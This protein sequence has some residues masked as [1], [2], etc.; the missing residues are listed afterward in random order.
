MGA[1]STIFSAYLKRNHLEGRPLSQVVSQDAVIYE[2]VRPKI[3][4]LHSKETLPSA[5]VYD[6]V[7]DASLALRTLPVG[8]SDIFGNA[9]QYSGAPLIGLTSLLY[10]VIGWA[11]ARDSY[12][13]SEQLSEIGDDFNASLARAQVVANGSIAISSGFLAIARILG[14]IEEFCHFSTHSIALP[15]AVTTVKLAATI[16]SSFFYLV[17]NLIYIAGQAVALKKLSDGNALREQL[18]G[19]KDPVK[20]L[21]NHIDAEMFRLGG[22]T[23]EECIEMAL[24]EGERWLEKLEK[25][26]EEPSWEQS[27]ESRKEHAYLLMYNNPQYMMAEMGVTEAFAKADP[28]ERIRCFGR[29]IGLKRLAAKIEN[30]LKL[31][32]GSEAME[33]FHQKPADFK[34][35]LSSAHWNEWGP[36]TKAVLKIVLTVASSAALIAGTIGTGGLALAIPVVVL[37]VVGLLWIAFGGDGA[38]LLT[39]LTS[40]QI[41]KRDKILIILSTVLSAIA[42]GSLLALTILSGGAIIY[43]AGV[44]FAIGWLAINIGS[45]LV[46]LDYHNNP[47][48]YQKEVTV[49]AFRKFLEKQHSDE[50]IG[51]IYAKMSLE[52]RVGIK[53]ALDDTD[54]L[55]KAVEVWD[56]YLQDLRQESLE[57]LKERLDEA[58][59][60]LQN[61]VAI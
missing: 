55:Q 15:A 31:E 37:G 53:K 44:V 61:S 26:M 38:A 1:V 2:T 13:R 7:A 47:W 19:S 3:N 21:S 23:K 16:I 8:L 42:L 39:Q 56:E 36:R 34:K 12:K 4:P 52:N 59:V 60:I 54:T 29:Y 10:C 17:F 22:F 27:S 45:C 5:K 43:I 28:E 49:T 50:E 6:A 9:V 32:L 57:I 58:S 11:R 40:G 46:L 41:S 35:I 14:I 33:T 18:L 48:I 25:E 20:A 51:K 24:Q 30:D